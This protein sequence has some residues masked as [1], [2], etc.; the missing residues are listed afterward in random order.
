VDFCLKAKKAG[1]E[2]WVDHD[3]SKECAHIGRLE[4][5]LEMIEAVKDMDAGVITPEV[6]DEEPVSRLILEA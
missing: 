6:E 5:K 3:L 2:I 4:Y 1:L